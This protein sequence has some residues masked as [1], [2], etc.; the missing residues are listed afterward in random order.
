[1]TLLFV[2]W[3]TESIAVRFTSF[4]SFPSGFVNLLINRSR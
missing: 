4:S 1:V 3:L 2:Y